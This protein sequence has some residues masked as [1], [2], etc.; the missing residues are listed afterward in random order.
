MKKIL[1]DSHAVL[2]W[3]QE[4]AGA[5]KV[6]DLLL[7]GKAN[8]I[9]LIM[10]RINL[11][12]VH[13]LIIRRKG[14]IAGRKFMASFQQLPVRIATMDEEIMQSATAIKAKYSISFADCFAVAAAIRERA[15]ILTGDPEFK[16]VQEIVNI[17][18]L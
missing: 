3:I 8:R 1:L 13:Y 2:K 7:A 10:N 6:E 18:W 5:R 11:A 9:E 16:E 12:E 15:T 17:Q 14:E 4:E